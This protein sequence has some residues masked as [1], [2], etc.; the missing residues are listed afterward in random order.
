MKPIL[1]ALVALAFASTA[2]AQESATIVRTSFQTMATA[3]SGSE[4]RDTLNKLIGGQVS[5]EEGRAG[6]KPVL[7]W[8][9]AKVS[10]EEV[11]Y[12]SVNN[13]DE[14]EDFRKTRPHAA[15]VVLIDI[16]CPMAYKSMAYWA[17]ED[18][19]MEAALPWLDKAIRMGPLFNE[20]YT[21]RGFVL[22]QLH[23]A[24]EGADSYR[25]AL[26]ILDRHPHDEARG[27]ALRGLGYSLVE[28]GDLPGARKA[29][30]DSLVVSPDNKGA[31]SELEY[32]DG[33][34]KAKQ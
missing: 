1:P 30:E 10:D 29:Y 18:G 9:D 23:R 19:D 11:T 16:A 15:K 28:T 27:V 21:E 32:I 22:N 24:A 4:H 7:D 34:L 6:V 31:Q 12:V 13:D 5:P 2:L 26:A 25:Q 20:A 8:C 17:V 14:A 33:L 3:Y